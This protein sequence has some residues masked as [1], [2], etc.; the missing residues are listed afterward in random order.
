[1]GAAL[2]QSHFGAQA[3]EGLRH[4]DANRPR[5]EDD[6]PMRY[7]FRAGGLAVRPDTIKVAQAR[8]RW[9]TRYRSGSDDN[10]LGFVPNIS[11]LDH[12]EAGE[13]SVAAQKID[14]GIREPACLPPVI[15]VRH[16]RVPPG[17]GGLHI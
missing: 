10:M 13:A 9:D 12:T 4:L 2:D 1:M 11:D 15:I 17:E 6:Q 14:L 16:D 8:H 3:T 7:R 5:A